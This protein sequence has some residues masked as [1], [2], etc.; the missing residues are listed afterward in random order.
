MAALVDETTWF[1]LRGIGLG[2][3]AIAAALAGGAQQPLEPAS[4]AMEAA[5]GR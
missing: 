3:A 4:P 1:I 5:D 2:D